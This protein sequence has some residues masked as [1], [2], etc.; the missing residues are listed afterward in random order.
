M[1]LFLV[2]RVGISGRRAAGGNPS[3]SQPCCLGQITWPIKAVLCEGRMVKWTQI[4]GLCVGEL[5]AGRMYQPPQKLPQCLSLLDSRG[6]LFVS[7]LRLFVS[8]AVVKPVERGALCLWHY[9][10]PR[11]WGLGKGRPIVGDHRPVT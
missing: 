6:H 4:R 2:I 7:F 5:A 9:L 8:A 10:P 11:N 1:G 3:Q